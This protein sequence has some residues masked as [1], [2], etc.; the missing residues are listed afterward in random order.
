VPT[1]VAPSGL[2]KKLGTTPLHIDRFMQKFKGR[3]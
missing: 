2:P 3:D 1:T